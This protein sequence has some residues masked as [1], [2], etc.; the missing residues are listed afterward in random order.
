M[1]FADRR[2]AK[3]SVE[4]G[5]T[6]DTDAGEIALE[7][8]SITP[9][10]RRALVEEERILE[11][12]V[13]ARARQLAGTL[14]RVRTGGYVSSFQGR[15]DDVAGGVIARVYSNA[16]GANILEW[17]GVIPAHDI[18]PAHARALHFAS[19]LSG[20]VFAARVHDPGAKIKGKPVLHQALAEM[21]SEILTGLVEA[22]VGTVNRMEF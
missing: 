17:G 3:V 8:A 16:K 5:F 9:R 11:E 21:Q 15:I 2:A 19:F 22:G 10:V 12:R 1:A 18:T 14:R 4:T 6:I 13:L 20:D 7:M